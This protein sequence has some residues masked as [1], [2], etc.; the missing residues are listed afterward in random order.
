[1]P[2]LARDGVYQEAQRLVRWH[3]QWLVVHDF[4]ERI[5]G[6][7]VV[8][9]ILRTEGY[10]A[11]GLTV[12]LPSFH[13]RF[14]AWR[15]DP[16]MPVEFSAAAYRFGHSMIRPDYHLNEQLKNKR[17]GREI[18]IFDESKTPDLRGSA[19]LKEN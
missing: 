8:D 3:Y 16:F 5:V 15:N 11:H 13:L 19:P 10:A 6:K 9:D 18:P 2:A 4:L 17:Q 7:Q 14:F 1:Q 12:G